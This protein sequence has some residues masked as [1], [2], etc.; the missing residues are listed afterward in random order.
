MY[1]YTNSR[2]GHPGSK[3]YERGD[4]CPKC[5]SSMSHRPSGLTVNPAGNDEKKQAGGNTAVCTNKKCG[6]ISHTT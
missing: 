1:D 6:H 5:N 2:R 3:S 4:Q